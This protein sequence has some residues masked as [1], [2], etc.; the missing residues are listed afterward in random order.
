MCSK[1]SKIVYKIGGKPMIWHVINTA[2]KLNS[3]GIYV[4]HNSTNKSMIINSL[5]PEM[6][7]SIHWVLQSDQFGTGH[8]VQQVLSLLDINKKVLILYADLPLITTRTLNK[9]LSIQLIDDGILLLTAKLVNP[10]EYGRVVRNDSGEVIKIAENA[11]VDRQ[12]FALK[13]VY[14]GILLADIV[15]LKY[16]LSKIT[17]DN[18]Q[19]EFYLTEIVDIAYR[20]GSVIN[21][22]EPMCINEIKG[23]NNKLQLAEVERLYQRRESER[24]SLSGIIFSD[25]DRFDL[26]GDLLHGLDV[27]I[28]NNVIIEGQVSLG[29][30]VKVG[31]GCILKNVVVGDDV[32]I[33]PYTIIDGVQINS[34]CTIGPFARL[35]PGCKLGKLSKIGNFVEMKN[36]YLGYGAKVNHFSYIGD[37]DIGLMI[38]IGAGAV[39]CNY[40][41]ISKHKTIIGDNVFIGSNTQLVAPITIGNS[42]T[43]GA[44]TTVTQNVPDGKT[45]VS[46]IRQFFIKN[47]RKS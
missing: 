23:V 15:H 35:R 6:I 28:D 47:R 42:V 33:L 4:V 21:T 20:K 40:D 46:R 26:R 8:A 2:V 32:V 18:K 38:N 27:Q 1:I 19:G 41:G 37:T 17:N 29:N 11:D 34:N 14:S 43:I 44:G 24:L 3:S 45:V 16:W 22:V 9:L 7:C 31:S 39:T 25:L 30:R 13:E 12:L 10:Q 36:V 5:D